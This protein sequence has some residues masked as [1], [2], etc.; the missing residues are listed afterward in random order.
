MA[1]SKG[2]M[3]NN[4]VP[5][6]ITD[7]NGVTTTRW[8]KPEHKSTGKDSIPPVKQPQRQVSIDA[9]REDVLSRFRACN[10]QEINVDGILQKVSTMEESTLRIVHAVLDKGGPDDP[11]RA[12]SWI[13]IYD[14]ERYLRELFT[15]YDAFDPETDYSFVEEAIHY[16]H[17]Y[18]V[19][20]NDEDY[21][22][23]AP[24]VQ[25]TIRNLLNVTET[26]LSDEYEEGRDGN[27]PIL[28]VPLQR[29]VVERPEDLDRI[30][31]IILDNPG[32]GDADRIALMLEAD[33]PSM[34]G[35]IL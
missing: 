9:V 19:L 13:D 8:V 2:I 24:E 29:L 35:G 33:A 12:G 32:L 5:K 16:L 22:R 28:P 31:D 4:L 3:N 14:S 23:S 18:E 15:Y 7:K 25:D 26:L 20:P 21:S 17:E 30:N 10:P 6:V 27:D 34:R 11:E 1:S